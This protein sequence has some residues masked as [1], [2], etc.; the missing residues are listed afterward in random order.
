MDVVVTIAEFKNH[1]KALGY[2]VSTIEVYRKGLDQFR[3]YLQQRDLS[4]LRKVTHQMILDYQAAVMAESIAQESKALK[5]R[6]VKRLF[7]HLTASHKLLI[8]PAE[9]IVET[10]RKN[11]K[12]GLVL[13]VDEM[14]KLLSCPNLSLKTGL[15][16]RAIMEVLYSTGVRLDELLNL[17][18]YHVDLKDKVLYIRKGKGRKQ[19]VT[20]LGKGALKYLKE[21]LHN[22]RPYHGRKHP[23]ERAL[24]LNHSG[25]ALC[26]GSIRAFL[27]TYRPAAGIKKA[28]SPHTFRRTCATHLLQQGAD[29]RYIQKLLGHKRLSTTQMYTKVMPIDLKATH[30]RTHPNTRDRNED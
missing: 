1:L 10:S 5:I 15:R 17:E 24:F 2:A 29:I 7:E 21:Y 11:R 30:N 12:I 19:R 6:P 3:Q 28:V 16:D 14:S 22:I 13:T 26:A 23:K 20:P 27:R 18:V 25:R 4:D 9:G 8:N